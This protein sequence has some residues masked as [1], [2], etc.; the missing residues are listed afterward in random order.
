MY[1][2]RSEAYERSI[3]IIYPR[4]L[5]HAF[6][7]YI[8]WKKT[9]RR[10]MSRALTNIQDGQ[11]IGFQS[12]TIVANHSILN[13]CGSPGQAFDKSK[14][15]LSVCVAQTK[16]LRGSFRNFHN[17]FKLSQGNFEECLTKASPCFWSQRRRDYLCVTVSQIMTLQYDFTIMTS[18]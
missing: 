12:L 6:M 14:N 17:F 2:R 18:D 4:Y 13:V 15:F 1:K 11:L 5:L 9:T 10:R 8:N 16:L 7:M 3:Y